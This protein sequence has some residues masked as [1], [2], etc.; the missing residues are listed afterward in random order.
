MAFLAAGVIKGTLG[1]G[2]PIAAVGLMTQFIDPRLAI[3]L[4]VFP[5]M[6]SNIWQMF[7]A[8][9]IKNTVIKYWIFAFVLAISLLVT[10]F[11]TARVAADVLVAFVGVVIILFSLM[12]L[13]STPP[14]IPEKVDRPSQ[15]IGGLIAGVMGGFTAIWSPPIAAY[16]IARNTDKDEFV[17]ATGFLFLIGSIPLSVGF[18]QNGLM[19][20]PVAMVS[21]GMIIPTIAG[22]SIGEIIRRKLNPD[23]FKKLVLIFFLLIGLNLIRKAIAG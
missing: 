13:I 15:L 3:S 1:V 4:V 22:F 23:R 9:E 10:T 17:R 8:G 16:L 18:W 6:F 7:R 14:S 19:T 11:Y 20:G 21:A 12:N 2:L 5:I